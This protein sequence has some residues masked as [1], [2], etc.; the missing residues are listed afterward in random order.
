MR[1]V[2]AVSTWE[3]RRI[4]FVVEHEVAYKIHRMLCIGLGVPLHEEGTLDHIQGPIIGLSLEPVFNRDL[5]S[6]VLPSPTIAAGIVPV[7]VRLVNEKGA[8][9]TGFEGVLMSR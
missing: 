9:L 2:M 6:L 1:L 5:Q 4:G 8:D 7:Q 3:H